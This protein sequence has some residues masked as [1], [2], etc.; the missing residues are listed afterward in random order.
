MDIYNSN[1]LI[2]TKFY[3]LINLLQTQIINSSDQSEI[4]KNKFKINSF[5]K[6]LNELKGFK[7]MIL[8]SDDISTLPGIGKGIIQ[9]VDEILETG[10]LKELN[11]SYIPDNITVSTNSNNIHDLTRVTGIGPV[12]AKKLSEN[13]IDLQKLL[14]AMEN[15]KYNI[16]IIGKG[17]CLSL[18]THHQLLGLKYFHDLEDRIPRKEIEEFDN[19]FNKI[20]EQIN[21]NISFKICGS[22]RRGTTDSGD[23]DILI[24]HKDLIDIESLNSYG[25]LPKFV[26]LLIKNNIIVDNLTSAGNT[27][28]MGICRLKEG[29]KARRIDIRC[30]PYKSFIPALLYFTGSKKH[31]VELRKLCLKKNYKLSEYNLISVDSG[32]EFIL[33][34]EEDLYKYL[35][36]EY[37][38]PHSR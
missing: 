11:N 18:L 31:N 8:S 38:S 19:I 23:M 17:S 28:Y 6:A 35:G 7:Y 9:R 29:H 27:K 16:D 34:C 37:V 24:S 25:M 5:K 10:N 26:N 13:N 20:I 1:K 15:N 2:V 36:I 3:E 14:D 21:K 30:V 32:E 12:K 33:N 22:F 4:K